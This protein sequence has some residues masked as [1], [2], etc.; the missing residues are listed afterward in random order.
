MNNW[1]EELIEKCPPE[2]AFDPNG[3]TFYRL[4]KSNPV[5]END[6]HSQRKLNPNTNFTNVSECIARSLSIW[7]D[8]EKCLNILKLPRHKNKA[9]LVMQLNLVTGDGLVLQTFK[10]NHYSWWRTNNYNVD[11][12]PII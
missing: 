11:S 8:I 3:L 7:D 2:N 10:P 4:A 1:T 9:P 12:T 5:T 6:F